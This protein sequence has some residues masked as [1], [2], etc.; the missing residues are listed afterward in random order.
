MVD[1]VKCIGQHQA[2][3]TLLIQLY[4]ASTHL[5]TFGPHPGL[6]TTTKILMYKIVKFLW[7]VHHKTAKPLTKMV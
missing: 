7:T 4:K 6:L 2:S 5:R 3:V 1:Y